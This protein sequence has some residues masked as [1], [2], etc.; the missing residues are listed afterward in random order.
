MPQRLCSMVEVYS[1]TFGPGIILTA[2][3]Y[4]IEVLLDNGR[5]VAGPPERLALRVMQQ[6]IRPTPPMSEMELRRSFHEVNGLPRRR[7]MPEFT[8]CRV[9]RLHWWARKDEP[10]PR[11]MRRR[12][13]VQLD[14]FEM[15]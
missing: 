1:D 11:C 15:G 10:C 3:P 14:L 6:Q 7:G 8:T 5:R 2:T 12:V 13:V 4:R 9:C